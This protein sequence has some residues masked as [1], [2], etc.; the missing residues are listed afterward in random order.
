MPGCNRGP[1]T[2]GT[3]KR[4]SASWLAVACDHC[5]NSTTMKE[6]A[7][8]RGL[9][10][11]STASIRRLVSGSWYS[12]RTSTSP[13]PASARSWPNTARLRDQDLCSDGLAR[14]LLIRRYSSTRSARLPSVARRRRPAAEV[15][16]ADMKIA[17]G[18]HE[19]IVRMGGISCVRKPVGPRCDDVDSSGRL[20]GAATV[21]GGDR[22]WTWR[23]TRERPPP[24]TAAQPPQAFRLLAT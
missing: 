23:L 3:S 9:I 24:C 6:S 14:C 2:C 11:A 18:Q 16:Y 4:V 12:T 1:A 22:Q 5:F 20:H 13:N 8:V 19:E 15:R 7:P 10:P 17:P 21:P